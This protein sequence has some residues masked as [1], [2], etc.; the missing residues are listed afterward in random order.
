ML[1]ET[2]VRRPIWMGSYGIGLERNM[3]AVVEAN[4]DERGIVWPLSVA[5]WHVVITMVKLDDATVAVGEDLYE[6]LTAAGL[7]VLL[8][9]RDERPGVKFTDAELIGIPL[10][11]TVGPRGLADGVVE[12]NERRTAEN[13][14]I[15]LEDAVAALVDRVFPAG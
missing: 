9:D 3:A 8:D 1:D 15:A 13:Q 7:D 2:G 10:R 11:V 12:V 4:H 6:R 5:P 14:T